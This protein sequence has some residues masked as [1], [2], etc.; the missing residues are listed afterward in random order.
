MRRWAIFVSG[1]GSNLQNVLELEKT[2][3]QNNQVVA[4]YADKECFAVE[5]AKKFNKPVLIL[6]PKEEG[7]DQKLIEFLSAHEANAIFLLGYMRIL[8]PGFL[9]KWKQPIVN[10]HPSILPKHKGLDAIKKAYEAG[11]AEFGVSL[12][13]VAPEVDSGP[14]LSQLKF[15]RPEGC[16]YEESVEKVHEMERKIVREYLFGLEKN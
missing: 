12:H 5:R 8:K 13:E 6:S 14:L 3:L 1:N 7:A 15:P 10:L 9:E 4:V 2:G 16:S 11:D